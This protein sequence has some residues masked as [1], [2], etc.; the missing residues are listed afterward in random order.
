MRV[1]SVHDDDAMQ[2][3]TR[4]SDVGGGCVRVR[5]VQVV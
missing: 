4:R 2:R 3:L 5:S 1:R